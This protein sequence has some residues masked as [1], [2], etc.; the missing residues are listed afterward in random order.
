VFLKVKI[1]SLSLDGR[2]IG[3]GCKFGNLNISPSPK[4]PSHK[5]RGV[6]L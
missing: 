6:Q 2:G 4:I 1:A 3:R 5:G